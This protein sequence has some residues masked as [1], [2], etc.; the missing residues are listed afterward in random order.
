V[1]YDH[2]S[3]H[4]RAELAR[5]LASD[6]ISAGSAV[7]TSL[8]QRLFDLKT[9]YQSKHARYQLLLSK[10]IQELHLFRSAAASTAVMPKLNDDYASLLNDTL[11]DVERA[12]LL[13]A[14]EWQELLTAGPLQHS[15]ALVQHFMNPH[16]SAAF[17]TLIQRLRKSEQTCQAQQELL[18][19]MVRSL[20]N[21]EVDRMIASNAVL[22]F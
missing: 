3:E 5:R 18:Q 16:Q 7:S 2:S 9:Y 4:D 14:S 1:F 13:T 19:S 22:D 20:G 11:P 10:C 8:D 15:P 12:E 17:V 21:D 6:D